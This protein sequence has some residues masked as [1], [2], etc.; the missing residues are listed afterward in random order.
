MKRT[1]DSELADYCSCTFCVS[2]CFPYFH[3]GPG[4]FLNPYTFLTLTLCLAVA[5]E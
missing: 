3:H 4:R 1:L 2:L 5:P